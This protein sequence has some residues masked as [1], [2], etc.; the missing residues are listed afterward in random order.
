MKKLATLLVV[1]LLVATLTACGGADPSKPAGKYL[2]SGMDMYGMKMA[3]VDIEAA[4]LEINLEF[5]EDDK[6]EMSSNGDVLELIVDYD[7]N[8]IEMD[9]TLGEFIF[10]DE[11][12]TIKSEEEGITMEMVF[13]AEDSRKWDEIKAEGSAMEDGVTDSEEDASSDES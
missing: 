11:Q 9:G 8:T 6:V 10:E 7:A 4:E 3:Y 1:M 5:K 2:L 12:F 13:T